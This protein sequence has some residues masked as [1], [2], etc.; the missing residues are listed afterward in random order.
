VDGTYGKLPCRSS[1]FGNEID[2][3]VGA[4]NAYDLVHPRPQV[5]L[6]ALC[7]GIVS[8]QM[9]KLPKFEIGIQFAINARQQVQ[10]EGR[11]NTTGSSYAIRNRSTGL[12]RSV[13][14]K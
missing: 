10:I 5:H 13:S 11:G 2:N 12:T 3:Q 14:K 4:A 8:D 9:L 7:L 1:H 6:D